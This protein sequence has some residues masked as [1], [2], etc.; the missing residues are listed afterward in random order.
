MID[1]ETLV[2]KRF[3]ASA[4]TALAVMATI[5]TLAAPYF[6]NDQLAKRLK[7]VSSERESIRQR[8]RASMQKGLRYQSKA[9]MKDVVDRFSLADWL[10]ADG[11]KAR[12]VMAGFRGPQGEIAFL[13]AR[14]V[15]P[16]GFLL[17]SIVTLYLFPEWDL[18]WPSKLGVVV[19]AT[20]AGIKAPEL[21]I[22]N[23]ISKRQTEMAKAF[24]DALDLMLICVESG[25]S[26]DHAVMKVSQ[27]IGP[28]SVGLA[29]E[30]ALASAELSYL[31]ERRLAYANLG[32]RTGLDSV[33]Q[34]A[35]VL[36]QAEKYGTPLVKALRLVA[37]ESREARMM[38]A[39]K[40]AASL[41][42][43]LTVPMIVFFLPALFAVIIGPVVLQVAKL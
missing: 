2:D 26:I 18:D 7:M 40:K 38:A 24:P 29:E 10:N 23:T 12:L 42:P 20:F 6:G 33:K 15:A 39:E 35:T 37:D 13:F 11:I 30:F 16:I 25:M 19:A 27:E 31:S 41:P 22:T 4:F 17:A 5:F 28:Q 1:I 14:F 36:I 8:E 32:A 9:Y 21:Y 3:V 43:K 34:I